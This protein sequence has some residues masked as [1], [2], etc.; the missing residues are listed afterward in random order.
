MQE[1]NSGTIVIKI[2]LKSVLIA[3]TILAIIIAFFLIYNNEICGF[4]NGYPMNKNGQTYGE[5][6]WEN[7][8]MPDLILVSGTN[9]IKG[10]IFASDLIKVNFKSPQEALE[11][12]AKNKDKL[13]YISAYLNDGK[14]V[15]GEYAIGNTEEPYREFSDKSQ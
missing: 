2:K 6:K 14:T 9:K 1:K 12:Q 10:Y 4:K 15:I 11:W 7:D 3:I 5:L 8:S 13:Q